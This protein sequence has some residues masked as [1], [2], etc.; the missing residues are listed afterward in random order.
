V[1]KVST[2]SGAFTL[3][4]EPE[5]SPVA[6]Q[7]SVKSPTGSTTTGNAGDVLRLTGVARDNIVLAQVLVSLNGG[8]FV[9][10]TFAPGTK[11]G[12]FDWQIDIVPENGANVVVIRSVDTGG[13]SS[14]SITL[15][16]NYTVKRPELAGSYNGLAI[17]DGTSNTPF[18]HTGVFTIK[19]LEKR[20][21]HRKAH[22]RRHASRRADRGVRKTMERHAS[23]SRV[24][25]C[26]T[27]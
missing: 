17:A 22:S 18:K 2:L 16:F 3:I 8:P 21:L 12:T 14:K 23:E 9:P 1:F 13:N 24:L 5:P 10:A 25:R 15:F 7:A 20:T 26:S 6:P 4:V 27:W 11:P 19:T